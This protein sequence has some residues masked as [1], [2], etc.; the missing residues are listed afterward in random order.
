[1]KNI[2]L[3]LVAGALLFSVSAASQKTLRDYGVKIG[4]MKQGANNS[5]TDVPGVKVGH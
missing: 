4:V 2:A 5:I 3:C 1:M